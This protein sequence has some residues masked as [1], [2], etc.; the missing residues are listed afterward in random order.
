MVSH[1]APHHLL[2]HYVTMVRGQCT[3]H[4][5]HNCV[6]PLGGGGIQVWG[7]RGLI[8][9]CCECTKEGICHFLSNVLDFQKANLTVQLPTETLTHAY[10]HSLEN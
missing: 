4:H 6:G 3:L 5:Y 7:N 1:S 9:K 10:A 2:L 8:Y